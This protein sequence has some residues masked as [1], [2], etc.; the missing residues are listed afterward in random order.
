MMTASRLLMLG[1]LWISVV[2]QATVI[3]FETPVV[4]P[5]IAS[6]SCDT[7]ATLGMTCRTVDLSGS[8]RRTRPTIHALTYIDDE[9]K[10][11]P[12]T[13]PT[14]PGRGTA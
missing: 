7:Y 2:L 12:N 14:Q 9:A 5:G 6:I 1:G 4:P 13:D 8:R 11:R 3:D 10:R